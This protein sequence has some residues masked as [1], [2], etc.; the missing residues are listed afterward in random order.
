MVFLPGANDLGQ[1]VYVPF[2][3]DQANERK[4]RM[5]AFSDMTI[6][7]VHYCN[8]N[9]INY[10]VPAWIVVDNLGHPSAEA[11]LGAWTRTQVYESSLELK[12][13]ISLKVETKA[14]W[15]MASFSASGSIAASFAMELEEKNDVFIGVRSVTSRYYRLYIPADRIPH[16]SFAS[17]PLCSKMSSLPTQPCSNSNYEKYQKFF[18]D[19]G[20]HFVSSLTVGAEAIMRVEVKKHYL[21]RKEDVHGFLEGAVRYMLGSGSGSNDWR[22]KEQKISAV[23]TMSVSA[24]GVGGDQDL[25]ATLA[26]FDHSA[27]NN[28]I[29][30]IKKN[31]EPIAYELTGIWELIPDSNLRARVRDAYAYLLKRKNVVHVHRWY[32]AAEKDWLSLAE[33][34]V[35]ED[36]LKSWGY[37]KHGLQ[38]IAWKIPFP[39]SVPVSRWRNEKDKD[40]LSLS[41]GEISATQ[42]SEWGYSSQKHQFYA[43]KQ[44]P[45]SGHGIAVYRWWGPT[46]TGWINI[47]DGEIPDATLKSWGYS[48]KSGPQFWGLRGDFVP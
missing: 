4:N 39:G 18:E 27:F 34:E 11:Y 48:S 33:N 15:S 37:T 5:R 17:T 32:H 10:D 20:T 13:S 42:L 43:A 30:S 44:P 24:G 40:W 1:T 2:D 23:S 36:T 38:F 9:G 22:H 28:W 45:E 41:E 8:E 14:D 29:L 12:K 19:V 26:S 46:E 47:A 3:V 7:S 21:L 35:P 31:P 16:P 25:L 6:E